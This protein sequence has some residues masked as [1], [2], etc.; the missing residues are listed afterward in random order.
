MPRW[1]VDGGARSPAAGLIGLAR[2]RAGH[3][4]NLEVTFVPRMS[5]PRPR[6]GAFV[7]KARR[8]RGDPCGRPDPRRGI[9]QDG[10]RRTGQAHPRANSYRPFS[11]G[12]T[13]ATWWRASSEPNMHGAARDP[14]DIYHTAVRGLPLVRPQRLGL[15]RSGINPGAARPSATTACRESDPPRQLADARWC[16]MCACGRQ[17]AETGA[18]H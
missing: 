12:W 5:A 1:C 2:I 16:S 9:G 3:F 11:A 17:P 7:K 15:S 10:G 13:A 6:A 4:R 8:Y 18:G 14:L